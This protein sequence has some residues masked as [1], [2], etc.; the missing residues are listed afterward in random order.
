[1]KYKDVK[2]GIVAELKDHAPVFKT[3][4]A[5]IGQLDEKIKSLAFRKPAAFVTRGE[6]EYDWVDGDSY[7]EQ[8]RISI[9]IATLPKDM[10]EMEDA[11]LAA[12]V[13]KNLG[14]SAMEMLVPTGSSPIF[15]NKL[16]VV[17]AL[18]FKTA[19]DRKVT[20]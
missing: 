17:R 9:I 14:F 7:N 19:F 20:G 12:L 4:E 8:D 18:E 5:Y 2:D 11:V 3:V 1:M 16:L 6:T 13:H 15:S 10:D